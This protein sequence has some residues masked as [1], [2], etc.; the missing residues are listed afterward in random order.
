MTT[1]AHI[2]HPAKPAVRKMARRWW[3]P[4]LLIIG[5]VL[6][7]V[8]LHGRLPSPAS[9]WAALQESRPVWLVAAAALQLISMWAFAEQQR[10]LLAAF[11]VRM[12][13]TAS[14]AVSYARSAMSTALPAGSAVSAGYAFRQYR[15]RGA[16]QPI[17]AAVMLLSGVASVAGLALLYGGALL[18]WATPS[19]DAIAI[20][21]VVIALLALAARRVRPAAA[22]AQSSV[23]AKVPATSPSTRGGSIV[24]RLRR[25]LGETTALARTVSGGRWLAVVALAVLNWLTDLACLLAAVHAVGLTVSASTVATAYLAAQLIRQI[26][27]T[28]GGIG[29]IEVSLILALTTAGAAAAPAAAAV[30]IYR[31]LSCWTVLPIGLL[32]WTAQN[33]SAARPSRESGG[34]A[35]NRRRQVRSLAAE[36]APQGTAST[37][38]ATPSHPARTGIG[39]G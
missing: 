16:S 17:A 39:R 21:A 12:P 32:C 36:S 8:E 1:A 30:L 15:A 38:P 26:P 37:R 28:P 34:V 13:P 31:L 24:W 33:P 20:A 14:I 23:G 4:A 19:R 35:V 7:V 3:R 18:A 10:Q 9:A 27:V 5:I 6:A 11:G 2:E 22:G 25:T 29:V